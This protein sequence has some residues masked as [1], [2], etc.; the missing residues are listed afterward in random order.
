MPNL[1]EAQASAL[2]SYRDLDETSRKR[3]KAAMFAQIKALHGIP[4]DRKIKFEIDNRESPSYCVIK[5]GV[6]GLPLDTLA[7]GGAREVQKYA[8]AP[9]GHAESDRAG[10]PAAKE[11]AAA[12]SYPFPQA[13]PGVKPAIHGLGLDAGFPNKAQPADPNAPKLKV[14]SISIQD[15]LEM[16]RLDGDTRDSFA[17]SEDTAHAEVYVKGDRIYYVL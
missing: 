6:T 10:T 5:D 11:E 16:L 9:W 3:R 1:T 13:K 8:P 2:R 12:P 17:H 14:G 4:K 7:K 15:L